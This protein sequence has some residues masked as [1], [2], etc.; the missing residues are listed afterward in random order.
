MTPSDLRPLILSPLPSLNIE[1]FVMFSGVEADVLSAPFSS[2][3]AF[4]A[5]NQGIGFLCSHDP[6]NFLS[7]FVFCSSYKSV[8]NKDMGS[9]LL[10][11]DI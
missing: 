8:T 10:L 6:Y 9:T 11:L 2:P 4:V 1:Y 3:V 5:V 7:Y